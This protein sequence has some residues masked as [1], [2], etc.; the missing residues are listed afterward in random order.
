MHNL[1]FLKQVGFMTSKPMCVQE[2]G[3]EKKNTG[4]IGIK[5]N[6]LF[7]I[8]DSRLHKEWLSW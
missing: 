6:T 3:R 4:E 8:I 1:L 7:T 5:E 2:F